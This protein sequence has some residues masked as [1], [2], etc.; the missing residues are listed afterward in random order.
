MV[1][2]TTAGMTVPCLAISGI[3]AVAGRDT[4]AAREVVSGCLTMANIGFGAIVGL[5]GG[6]AL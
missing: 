4:D 2:Y 1:F 5:I 3:L 6:R